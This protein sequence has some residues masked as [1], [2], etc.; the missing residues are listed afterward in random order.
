[1][2][3]SRE[4]VLAVIEAMN[5]QNLDSIAGLLHEDVINLQIPVGVEKRGRDVMLEHFPTIFR[6]F[7]DSNTRC[8]SLFEDGEWV[9]CEW[10][11]SGTWKGEFS[12]MQPNGNRF[13]FRGCEFYQ[14]VDGKIKV[15][16]GYWDKVSWFSQLEISVA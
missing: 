11:Y 16:R 15:Q 2:K 9:V 5:D 13:K 10:E 6:A 3:T 12:G 7:P 8:I 4:T 1:M 14:I